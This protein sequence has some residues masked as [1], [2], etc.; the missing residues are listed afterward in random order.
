MVPG[1]LTNPIFG[2]GR[3]PRACFGRRGLFCRAMIRVGGGAWPRRKPPWGSCPGRPHAPS[4][5]LRDA[6]PVA[7]E[8]LAGGRSCGRCSGAGP[9]WR[10][11]RGRARP[12]APRLASLG[13]NQ[14]GHRRHG[15]LP[16]FS[17]CAGSPRAGARRRVIHD[18]A[19][20]SSAFAGD[21][22]AGRARGGQLATPI[23]FG[24]RVARWAQ[25][26]I[27][28]R[29]ELPGLRAGGAQ[30]GLQ[31]GGWAAGSRQVVAP[32]GAAIS[33][34]MAPHPRPCGQRAVARR[35][36]AG[37]VVW[38]QLACAAGRSPREDRAVTLRFRRAAEVSEVSH[39]GRR[40]FLHHAAQVEPDPCR[41]GC[42]RWRFSPTGY[43]AGL[44]AAAVHA[45][46]R[47]GV[48]WPVEWGLLAGAFRDGPGRPSKQAADL[49]KD[50]APDR[51]AMQAR[52]DAAPG[53]FAE[54][55]V[56]CHCAQDR[57]RRQR[58][59]LDRRASCP[60]RTP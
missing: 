33:A 30:G 34:G 15:L 22:D 21:A 6:N 42:N 36:A 49:V 3:K 24:L 50:M 40:K 19:G 2:H 4:L 26:L 52:I 43:E 48:M 51:A 45:E 47:D 44:S 8:I 25:P 57:S 5:P 59:R 35:A 56:L 54:A 18:L 41:G 31:F 1:F 12:G 14:P 53:V 23:S 16:V 9:W 13:C 7:P 11:L 28:L 58:E 46:E 38:G 29:E 60:R 27:G 37:S 55:I 39:R 17:R 10:P 20:K 32:H